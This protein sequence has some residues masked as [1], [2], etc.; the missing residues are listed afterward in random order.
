MVMPS[1]LLH[2]EMILKMQKK[3]LDVRAISNITSS[4]INDAKRYFTD[5]AQA[6]LLTSLVAVKDLIKYGEDPDAI[7]SLDEIHEALE[8]KQKLAKAKESYV[9]NIRMVFKM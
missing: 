6:K 4:F 7:P 5:N 1:G 9:K 2:R 3:R 8:I